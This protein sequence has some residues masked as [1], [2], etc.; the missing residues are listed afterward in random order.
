MGRQ[1]GLLLH[2]DDL[3]HFEA[4]LRSRWNLLFFPRSVERAPIEPLD[5]LAVDFSTMSPNDE[6]MYAVLYPAYD[7]DYGFEC[8]YNPRRRRFTVCVNASPVMEFRRCYFDGKELLSGR[9]YFVPK[10][11]PPYFVSWA[12]GVIKWVRRNYQRVGHHYAGQRALEWRE[13]T[14]GRFTAFAKGEV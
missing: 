1:A 11:Y 14:H 8:H 3:S 13:N 4:E 12:D 2:P 9:V 6:S 10:G 5:T 7:A